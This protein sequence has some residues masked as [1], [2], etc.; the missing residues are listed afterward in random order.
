MGRMSSDLTGD[1]VAHHDADRTTL[2]KHHVEHLATGVQLH[3]AE[4]DL[5]GQCLICAE[6]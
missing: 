1:Q 5:F 6:Q 3:G 4:T 2:V